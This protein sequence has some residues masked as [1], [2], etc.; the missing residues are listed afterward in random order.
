MLLR[1]AGLR[2][3]DSKSGVLKWS[4]WFPE[5]GKREKSPSARLDARK[6][7]WGWEVKAKLFA[8][9][10]VWWVKLAEG[11]KAAGLTASAWNDCD[12]C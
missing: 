6:C 4:P 10:A 3:D 5:A 7:C 2:L 11:S 12:G 8:P 9:E 1:S